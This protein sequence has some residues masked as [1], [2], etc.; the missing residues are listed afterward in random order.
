MD[1]CECSG[2]KS[3]F[4]LS[5]LTHIE[6]SM[7]ATK[8]IVNALVNPNFVHWSVNKKQMEVELHTYVMGPVFNLTYLLTSMRLK[9]YLSLLYGIISSSMKFKSV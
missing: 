1:A 4:A 6:R 9:S 3:L 2:G 7:F 8:P 5:T